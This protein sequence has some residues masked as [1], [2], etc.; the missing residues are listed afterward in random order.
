LL[1]IIREEE[2]SKPSTKVSS[3]LS[4]PSIAANRRMEPARLGN[5]IRGEL[6]WIV[7]KA[8]EEGRGRRYETASKF[9]EDVQHYLNDEA[10]VACPPSATYRIT[11]YVRRNRSPLAIAATA[12]IILVLAASV[13]S[14]AAIRFRKLASDNAQLIE[15]ADDSA[16][17]SSDPTR[18][19]RDRI[20]VYL[21]FGEYAK[22]KQ[23]FQKLLTPE[24]RRHDDHYMHALLALQT[25]DEESYRQSCRKMLTQFA[26]TDE[27]LIA[28]FT[29]WT[30]VLLPDAVSNYS[31][32]VDLARQAT[33]AQPK[34]NQF[35]TTLGAVLYRAGRNQEALAT[36]L[37]LNQRLE[38]T[39]LQTQSSPAYTW[40][41]LA[42][43]HAAAE[44]QEEA[45]V[46]LARANA[47]TEKMLSDEVNPP[48]WNQR[49]TLEILRREATEKVLPRSEEAPANS[50]GD[51]PNKSTKD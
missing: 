16:T 21:G 26:E 17:S 18:A 20:G 5:M 38:E 30:C 49:L 34:N 25:R 35:L 40:Y 36:L 10:V 7:L 14:I 48:S 37:E 43:T 12:A 45:R 23:D 31:P 4:L 1:R 29:A 27:S 51:Q 46:V 28:N 11:K 22:A 2:P 9:A 47:W 41:F 42:M 50:N 19:R 32:A 13:S 24:N 39:I 15:L 44:Q 3:S 8:M 33:E 6:D